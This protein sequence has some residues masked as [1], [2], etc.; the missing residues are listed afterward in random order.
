MY[1]T[2]HTKLNVLQLY[3]YSENMCRTDTGMAVPVL[4]FT[5][6]SNQHLKVLF[7]NK[8]VFLEFQEESPKKNNR[9][10]IHNNKK[11]T[12]KNDKS[13]EILFVSKHRGQ[14]SE[15]TTFPWTTIKKNLL[16]HL[17]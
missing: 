11:K 13:V 15:D 14:P 12:N 2:N 8:V 5:I 16:L 4:L 9:T 3:P 10:S 6:H 17:T 1:G 7:Q